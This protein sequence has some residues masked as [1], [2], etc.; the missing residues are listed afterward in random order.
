MQRNV[1]GLDRQPLDP[2]PRVSQADAEGLGNRRERPIVMPPALP[3][4]STEIVEGQQRRQNQVGLQDLG[5]RQ[6]GRA[7][8]SVDFQRIAR[9]PA[10]EDHGRVAVD[11]DGKAKGPALRGESLGNR[12]RIELAADGAVDRDAGPERDTVD[13][14]SDLFGRSRIGR[15]QLPPQGARLGAK[16]WLVEDGQTR[17]RAF[18]S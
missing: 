7:S 8:R 11:D 18:W 5:Q 14:P 2:L 1:M 6:G 13:M 3:Q 16:T 4:S 10:A 9:R 15:C 17:V 12:S